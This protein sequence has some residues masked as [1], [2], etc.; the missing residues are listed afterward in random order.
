MSAE[1]RNDMRQKLQE[2][3]DMAQYKMLRDKAIKN[4]DVVRCNEKGMY[5]QSARD[6][7]AEVYH[8]DLGDTKV[9]EFANQ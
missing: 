8:E 3:L 7:F 6:A 9:K 1:E 2:G 4:Q 5:E